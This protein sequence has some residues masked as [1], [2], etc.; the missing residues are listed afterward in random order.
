ML[1]GVDISNHQLTVPAGYDFYILKASEGNGFKDPRLDSHYNTLVSRGV[2]NYGFYHYARPDLG[3][4]PKAEADWFL[5]LVGHH[6]GKCIYALD[7]EGE[8]LRYSDYAIWAKQ[9]LDYVYAKTGVK[10][11]LYI[12]GSIASVMYG[13]I[14][15]NDYGIWAASSANWYHMF[16]FIVIQ[17]SVYNN[18]DH[19]TF[20]GTQETWDKYCG[21]NTQPSTPPTS[22]PSQALGSTLDLAYGVMVGIYGDDK[23]RETKLGDR[24][25]EVQDFINHIYFAPIDD[26]VAETM[27]GTYGNDPIRRTVLGNRYGTVMGI[28]NGLYDSMR[29]Y[30][31][32]SGDT[33]SAIAIR[34]GTTVDNILKLNPWITNPDY[35]QTGWTIRV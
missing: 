24:Y 35:I 4:S 16:P 12:Q 7:L 21:K 27:N 15:G 28:I 25:Q 34:Y 13:V 6:A 17:Q 23:V 3:N 20:Y 26:L 9:W 8:A 19:D 33:L 11:L 31:I 5:Y 10:P 14:G 29:M 32:H 22:N 30:T 2:K 1:N 18:L